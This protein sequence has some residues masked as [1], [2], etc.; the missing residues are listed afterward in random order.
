MYHKKDCKS[1]NS[2]EEKKSDMHIP[3]FTFKIDEL[4]RNQEPREE[5]G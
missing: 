4:S 2:L 5:P 1:R 3:E